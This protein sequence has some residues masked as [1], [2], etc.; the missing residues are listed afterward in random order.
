V[1]VIGASKLEFSGA[2][3]Y[4]LS[5]ERLAR[6]AVG[7]TILLERAMQAYEFAIG[8]PS[9][10]LADALR[11]LGWVRWAATEKLEGF[12][13]S[14]RD[15]D[16]TLATL[17]HRAPSAGEDSGRARADSIRAMFSGSA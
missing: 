8:C 16:A 6:R 7:R 9:I 10:S 15:V 12:T 5:E 2:C 1:S 4:L 3:E 14:T 11:V 17:E 13:I